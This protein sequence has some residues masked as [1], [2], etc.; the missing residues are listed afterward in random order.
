MEIHLTNGSDKMPDT[1]E[2]LN[3][4]I[5]A[6]SLLERIPTLA[7]AGEDSAVDLIL[8]E[9][10]E[11]LIKQVGA[12]IG[13]I[14]LFPKGGRSEKVCIIK[15]GEPW[16][17]EEMDFHKFDPRRGFTSLVISSGKS[18]LVKDIW[19]NGGEQAPNPFLELVSTMNKKYIDEIKR[20]VASMIILPIKRGDEVFCTIELNCH[21]GKKIFN[22]ENKDLLDDFA[23]RYGPLIMN[24]VLDIK[25]RVAINTAQKR[26]LS[27][28]RLIACNKAVDYRQAVEPYTKLSAADIVLV[29]FKTGGMYD[30][31]YRLL[32][33]EGKDIRE[34]LL[35][36]FLPSQNSILRYD[37]SVVFPVQGEKMDERITRF[38]DK[39]G[40]LPG[41]REDDCEFVI[42]CLNQIESYVV[43]PLHMLSQ[44]LGVVILGSR[45]PKFWEYLHM[46]PFLSLY[47]SLL[48]SF[49]LNERA[50]Y[51]LSDFSLKIHNPG[52]YC[53]GAL[54]GEIA[55]SSPDL[56]KNPRV[57]EPLKRLDK[58]FTE[59]H[60][61]GK[62]LRWHYKKIHIV[63]WLK[64]YINPKIAQY[65]HFKINLFLKDDRISEATI[66]ASD[67]QLE[68]IFENLFS[69]SVRAI[70]ARQTKDH[71]LI[72]EVNITIQQKNKSVM[73]RF[74]DNGIQYQTVSGRGILQINNEMKD[75]GGSV[76]IKIKPYQ[77]LLVFP[78]NYE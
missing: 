21:R 14:N 38:C 50:I 47:N 26:L 13:Q 37:G 44:E 60:E 59:L 72:G 7:L 51:Y 74:Q 76:S 57:L 66:M 29:F 55:K 19:A 77:I 16:L 70:T 46:N 17:K 62:A 3:K 65:P 78:C 61:Q 9:V 39:I 2:I 40:K 71:S 30:S 11:L 5:A 23:K 69:N 73:V 64:A 31:S 25:N 56:L 10:L 58:L 35:S 52:F 49:L 48:K 63:A 54:K 33:W 67:E 4:G 36:R 32:A 53:L 34:V 12:D 24:Y 20:P 8:Y 15:D 45:R 1:S 75:L 41:I 27:M 43:T 18:I 28:A 42:R 6:D 68:T 22:R